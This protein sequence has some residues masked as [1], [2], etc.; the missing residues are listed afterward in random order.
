MVASKDLIVGIL[1]CSLLVSA[2]S[3]AV[4]VP[5]VE[6]DNACQEKDSEEEEED[7]K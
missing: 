4:Q 7:N 6:K 3:F 2:S 5:E 1:S